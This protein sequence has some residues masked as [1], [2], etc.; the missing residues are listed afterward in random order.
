MSDFPYKEIESLEAIPEDTHIVHCAFQSLDFRSIRYRLVDKSFSDCL[1]LGCIIPKEMD[2]KIDLSC[3]VLPKLGMPYKAFTN[4][5]YTP[6][7][8]YEGYDPADPATFADCF[9]S[10][11]YREYVSRG[12]YTQD[13]RETLGRTIH[14]HSITDAV[15]DFV[16]RYEKHNVVSIMGGHAMKRSDEEY[17]KIVRI[18]KKLTENGK[19]MV[20]GGGPGAMEATHFGAWMAGRSEEELADAV[21][22]LSHAETFR[23]RGWLESA[24]AVCEKY[25][26]IRFRSLGIP[27]WLYGHEPSTPF[28]TDIAKFFDNSLRENQIISVAMGGIIFT[29]GSAGTVREIFQD[30]EQ[31]HYRTLGHE[32]PMVFLGT[33]FYRKEVPVYGFLQQMLNHERYKHLLLSITDD[34]NLIIK[35]IMDF[36]LEQ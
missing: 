16:G 6:E 22:M 19:L 9:D 25:P 14:D 28:A 8:L 17:M 31:N 32:S 23:D 1:F 30:A 3:L 33:S 29:P 5:L 20:S 11:I 24:F 2:E 35:T 10:R 36:R 18:S 4:S 34:E 12:K 27:T 7:T 13:I 26:Q 15:S 21:R